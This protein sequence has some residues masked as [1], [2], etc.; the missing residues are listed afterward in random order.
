MEN[1]LTKRARLTPARVAVTDGQKQ[2]TFSEVAQAA[3]IMA[4][5]IAAL[6]STRTHD[7]IALL[8]VNNISGYLVI[9]AL[10]Q[11]GKTKK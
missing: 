7:R 8:M 1:W 11:L 5:R 2:M 10:Q 6:K 9:M 3:T 4:G